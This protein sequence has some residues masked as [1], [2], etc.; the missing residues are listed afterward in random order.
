M[1]HHPVEPGQNRCP[2]CRKKYE[3]WTEQG[4]L[5]GPAHP[6]GPCKP[7]GHAYNAQP[8]APC[9]ECGEVISVSRPGATTITCSPACKKLRDD[10]LRD[11]RKA[12]KEKANAEYARESK[13]FYEKYREARLAKQR[14]K[15]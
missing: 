3:F 11:I 7:P 5:H 6:P 12:A 10:K 14:K 9:T 15:L 4:R 8:T 1:K 13:A 2:H